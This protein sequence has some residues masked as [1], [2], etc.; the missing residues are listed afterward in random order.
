MPNGEYTFDAESTTA[1][2]TCGEKYTEMVV[3]DGNGEITDVCFTAGT[4]TVTDTLIEAML[5][6]TEGKMH[7]VQCPNKP[8]DNIKN[9]G[10]VDVTFEQ[11][12]LTGDLAVSFEEPVLSA[13]NW[14][15][16]NAVG[17]DFWQLYLADNADYQEIMLMLHAELGMTFP[18]GTYPISGD[19]SSSVALYGYAN[20]AKQP[21]GC[22]Y[23]AFNED[24]SELVNKAAFK[25]GSVT[26][27]DNNDGTYTISVNAKDNLGNTIT[28]SFVGVPEKTEM[29]SLSKFS[30]AAKIAH[31]TKRL[32]P[33]RVKPTTVIKR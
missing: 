26:V 2:N 27:A 7:H 33:R 3:T 32:A 8:V 6:S 16:Y 20:G 28:S 25:S 21:Y 23:L 14:G 29:S 12:T 31:A 30:T 19:I 5:L 10:T 18:V 15:D 9:Y 22:W 1:A 4:I 13:E 24:W 17:K 11:S